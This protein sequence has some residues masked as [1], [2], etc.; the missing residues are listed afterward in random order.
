MLCIICT[1]LNR[2]KI[3]WLRPK[4]S[5]AHNLAMAGRACVQVFRDMGVVKHPIFGP[6]S[7]LPRMTICT[8]HRAVMQ[9]TR[10]CNEAL[11][12]EKVAK[13]TW[14]KFNFKYQL[15]DL[16][17]SGDLLTAGKH[18]QLLHAKLYLSR[19]KCML[20]ALPSDIWVSCAFLRR[21]NCADCCPEGYLAYNDY[22]FVTIQTKGRWVG[23]S[24]VRGIE[25]PHRALG[26]VPKVLVSQTSGPPTL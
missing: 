5:R 12:P 14:E 10:T 2:R 23:R 17:A 15:H 8:C 6:P 20:V 7:L 25:G 11:T 21:N 22:I 13:L 18:L 19:R 24:D 9:A 3:E 26:A 4:K 16:I 1:N